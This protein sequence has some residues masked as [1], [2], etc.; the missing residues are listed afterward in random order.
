VVISNRERRVEV[1]CL[2][3]TAAKTAILGEI[4]G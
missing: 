4:D 3:S 2:I 1:V